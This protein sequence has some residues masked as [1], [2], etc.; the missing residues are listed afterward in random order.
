M[1]TRCQ[2][3]TSRT[4]SRNG[5]CA[6][7]EICPKRP[8]R[9]AATPQSVSGSVRVLSSMIHARSPVLVFYCPVSGR[10]APTARRPTPRHPSASSAPGGPVTPIQS[11]LLQA[12]IYI[13]NWPP[14]CQQRRHCDRPGLPG[15]C[16][17]SAL[18]TDFSP[19]ASSGPCMD[20]KTCCVS[21]SCNSDSLF[22]T[23]SPEGK[24]GPSIE[25]LT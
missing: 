12:L 14:L 8:F 13:S 23:S 18:L 15:A 7:I 11:R 19:E 16:C 3:M 2:R 17:N 21:S 6:G 10:C 25:S 4:C 1:R 24:S 20:V 9:N 22:N 5:A